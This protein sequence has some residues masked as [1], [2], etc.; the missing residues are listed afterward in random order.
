MI[1][2]LDGVT[3]STEKTFEQAYADVLR[4][5]KISET[6]RQLQE[7][8]TSTLKEFDGKQTEFITRDDVSKIEGLSQEEASEFLNTVFD[9]QDKLGYVVLSDEKIVQYDVLEQRLLN[10]PIT[11]EDNKVM[12]IKNALLNRGLIQSLESKYPVEMFVKGL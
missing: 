1:L 8:A 6:A 10:T 7:L 3:A 5:Y 9:K 4:A 2:K 11:D 12:Q